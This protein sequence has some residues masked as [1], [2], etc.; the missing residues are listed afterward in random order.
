MTVRSRT[1]VLALGL[2][3]VV[4]GLVLAAVFVSS[5]MIVAVLGAL[6]IVAVAVD[7]I[8]CAR[9]EEADPIAADR[10]AT[11]DAISVDLRRRP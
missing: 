1:L 4:G 10:T 6:T 7:S 5:W 11:P 8:A 3:V 9:L 2:T